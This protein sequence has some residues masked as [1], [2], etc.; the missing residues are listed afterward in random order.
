M[1]MSSKNRI[2]L[3]FTYLV[4]LIYY[5]AI[6]KTQKSSVYEHHIFMIGIMIEDANMNDCQALVLSVI[7]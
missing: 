1:T 4:L 5:F 7:D 2:F 3:D 6:I